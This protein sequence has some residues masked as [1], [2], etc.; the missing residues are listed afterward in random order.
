[1]SASTADQPR[2]ELPRMCQTHRVLL[3]RQAGYGPTDPWMAL[4]VVTG[5]A[6]FQAATCDPKVRAEIDGDIMRMKG[7]GCLACRKPDAFGEI[8]QAAQTGGLG[9]IKALGEGWVAAAAKDS[10]P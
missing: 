10:A 9:A 1:M 4:E 8:V 7:L 3:V 2:V 5:I 6:L